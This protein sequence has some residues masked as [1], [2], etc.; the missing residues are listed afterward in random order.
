LFLAESTE[1]AAEIA[2]TAAG[3]HAEIFLKGSRFM[4]MERI[5]DKLEDSWKEQR[6]ED[7]RRSSST[8]RKETKP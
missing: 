6:G 7:E 4:Q 5:V 3:H 8:G 2:A 1:Q